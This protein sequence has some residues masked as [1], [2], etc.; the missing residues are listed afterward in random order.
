MFYSSGHTML[1]NVSP[2]NPRRK[3][4][5]LKSR[6]FFSIIFSPYPTL[7]LPKHTIKRMF[8]KMTLHDEQKTFLY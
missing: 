4:G 7:H 5:V 1:K 2:Q 3:A 8:W 6:R